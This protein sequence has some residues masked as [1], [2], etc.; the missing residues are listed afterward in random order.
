[1]AIQKKTRE[2]FAV[3][4]Q[5]QYYSRSPQGKVIAFYGPETFLLRKKETYTEG[6]KWKKTIVK[7]QRE[8][9]PDKEI[10]ESVPNIV[11]MPTTKCALHVVR[12]YHLEPRLKEKLPDYAGVRTCEITKFAAVQLKPTEG[13]DL[14]KLKIQDMTE[15]ELLQFIAIND[16]KLTLSS[17]R[18]LAT[19]K[20]A[21]EMAWNK[22]QGEPTDPFAAKEVSV[23]NEGGLI[24][25]DG[26]E[27]DQDPVEDLLG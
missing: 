13:R 10:K 26:I 22:R 2:G 16:M 8:G 24:G 12:R 7:S 14:D 17:F 1:M 19:K 4:V 25:L 20:H 23:V 3:T 15:S 21:V 9:E 18:D 6:R 5:G 27:E 11:T